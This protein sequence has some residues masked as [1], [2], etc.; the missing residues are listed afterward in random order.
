MALPYAKSAPTSVDGGGHGYDPDDSRELRVGKG[1]HRGI[2]DRPHIFE[3]RWGDHG[4]IASDYQWDRINEVC[5][6]LGLKAFSPLWRKDQEMLLHEMVQA[7]LR[8]IIVNVSA[9]GLGPSWLGRMIDNRAIEELKGLQK[10]FSINL[11]GEGGEY[12]TLVIDSPLY[13]KAIK[14]DR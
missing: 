1:R 7:G 5:Q 14:I 4:G 12:E 3:H 9:E 13:K 11:S 10:R 8:A 2:A 6:D